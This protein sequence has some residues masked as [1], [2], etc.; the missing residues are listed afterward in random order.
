MDDKTIWALA[1]CF[2]LNGLVMKMS[3]GYEDMQQHSCDK[4]TE[5]ADKALKAFNKKFK[6]D[7]K[8]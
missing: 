4:A 1:Y 3:D 6:E 5:A 2:A 7:V 8:T